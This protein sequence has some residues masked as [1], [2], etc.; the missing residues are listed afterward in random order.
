MNEGQKVTPLECFLFEKIFNFIY[1]SLEVN[2]VVVNFFQR[3]KQLTHFTPTLPTLTPAMMKTSSL[4]VA[5]HLFFLIVAQGQQRD[6]WSLQQCLDHALEHN[7]NIRQSEL[8]LKTS[9]INLE[10]SKAARYPN[11]NGSMG[12]SQNRGRSID[13][14]SNDFT[15]VTVNSYNMS[16]SSNVTLFN[17][18]RTLNTIR[19]NEITLQADRLE[20]E[21]SKLDISLQIALAYLNILFNDELLASAEAQ[22]EATKSQRDR[23]AKLVDAGTLAQNSLLEIESQIATEELNV[24][25]ARNTLEVAHLNLMQ[26]LMLDPTQPFGI[27]K[28]DLDNYEMVES[29]V[30][31]EQLYESAAKT[32]PIIRSSELRI[33]GAEVG[34]KIARGFYWPTLTFSATALT[35]YS[36]ATQEATG[37]FREQMVS[38]TVLVSG[39]PLDAIEQPFELTLAQTALIPLRAQTPFIDQLNNNRRAVFSL[40]LNIPI[41][42]RRQIR[43]GVE[44]AEIARQQAETAALIQEQN[45]NQNIQQAY[46]DAR[47]ALSTY[48]QTVRQIDALELAFNN[49]QKQFNLGVINSVDFIL[50]KT[51]LDRAR[52][53]LIRSKYNYIFRT[54]VLDFYQGKPIGL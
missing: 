12:V 21:Q 48:R 32:Q 16:V 3:L 34:E 9:Q 10:E 1:I 22:V 44:R 54:K 28:P 37:E 42:N 25:N 2:Q 5:V 17:G 18:L 8:S 15:D 20:L 36:S 52:F 27:E 38:D 30:G 31:L 45:L 29:V 4:F 50:A 33:Q 53:D 24:V 11:L 7:L 13:P 40:S 14:F 47:S 19:Q 43:S 51:N 23:T 39:L 41:Y 49:S 35:G 6:I 46:V 26:L